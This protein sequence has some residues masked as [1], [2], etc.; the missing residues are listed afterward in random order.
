MTFFV[1][2]VA[3]HCLAN[4]EIYVMTY[5]SLDQINYVRFCRV[6]LAWNIIYLAECIVLVGLLAMILYMT[7][8][9]TKLQDTEKQFSMLYHAGQDTSDLT[10]I[11]KERIQILRADRLSKNN[12]R[13][14]DD[15]LAIII[16]QMRQEEENDNLTSV[17]LS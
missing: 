7:V 9:Y 5:N 2:Y 10:R 3:Q 16:A 6:S 15:F 14:A 12:V 17:N 1:L 8:K 13:L 4:T 11:E